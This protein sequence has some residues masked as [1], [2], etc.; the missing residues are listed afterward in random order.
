MQFRRRG[1]GSGQRTDRLTAEVN[2]YVAP[3][4]EQSG[5]SVLFT[6]SE[7]QWL[8]SK[9]EEEEEEETT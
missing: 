5:Q 1:E 7:N 3:G 4:A 6:S 2:L 9:E 8:E